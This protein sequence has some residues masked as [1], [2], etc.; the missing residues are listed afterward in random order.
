MDIPGMHGPGW[1][2][3]REGDMKTGIAGAKQGKW[4]AAVALLAAPIWAQVQQ[5][6]GAA[7]PQVV[8]LVSDACP[9]VQL[10]GRIALDWNPNFDPPGEV[11][12][13]RSFEMVFKRLDD[14]GVNVMDQGPMLIARTV[15]TRGAIT[16]L[17]NGF[18]HIE[19]TIPRNAHAGAFRL[20]VAH[21]R[22]EV[23]PEYKDSLPWPFMTN[24]PV[25]TRLCVT[26]LP[27]TPQPAHDGRQLIGAGDGK[28]WTD[29]G[30]GS[31]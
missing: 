31:I 24:S 16:P 17:G 13:L 28:S 22:A 14:Y 3:G 25:Q 8:A 20:V 7:V 9:T 18:Y 29:F 6:P 11:S 27:A 30:Q 2:M 4:L 5:P 12:G 23:F 15:R 10:G 26:V 21:A 19:M 1:K